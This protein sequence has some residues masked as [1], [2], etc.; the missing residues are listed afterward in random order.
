VSPVTVTDRPASAVGGSV[1]L[2]TVTKVFGRGSSA[3]RALDQISLQVPQ[4]EFTCLIGASGCG[5]STL[6]SLVAGLE[7]PTSGA[8]SVSGRVALMFQ[9]PA[10]F[11]WLSA[12]GNVE[13]A[14]RARGIGRAER[15]QRTAELIEAVHLGGFGGKRPHELSGGMR[16]RVALAR[17]LAQD[18]DVLLMDEPFGALDA[19]TRDLLHDELDR[20]CAGRQLTIIF[21]T[22]N[23]REAVRLGDRVVVLSSRP[24][25][26]IDEFAVPI[27]HPRRIDSAPVAE[28]AGQI[29]D[30]LREEMSHGT[31]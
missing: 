9:E 4:G 15:R 12:A 25:R 6:L 29:T 20:V 5:K 11:P 2:T 21:V 14:L 31:Q 23:V 10:L 16:Q 1:Q 7:Q 27:E 30:R 24:G 28:L 17:A 8:V 3:V 19:M 13:V 22:H 18:A 26:V